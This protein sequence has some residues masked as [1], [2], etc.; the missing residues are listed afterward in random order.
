[1]SNIDD[2]LKELETWP[3]IGETLFKEKYLHGLINRDPEV[4]K[5]WMDVCIKPNIPVN[6]VNSRGEVVATV[7]P[8]LTRRKYNLQSLD[9]SEVLAHVSNV[10]NAN[11]IAANNL[12]NKNLRGF[13]AEG[14]HTEHFKQWEH[15]FKYFNVVLPVSNAKLS[16]DYADEIVEEW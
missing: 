16:G 2:I 3:E 1:M 14:D 4:C 5:S 11:P 12:L 7:P 15:I 8:I 13:Y 6:I 10:H 9:M